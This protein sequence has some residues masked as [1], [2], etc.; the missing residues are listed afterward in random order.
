MEGSKRQIT[1]FAPWIVA[2]ICIYVA[3]SISHLRSVQVLA[4][5]ALF[6]SVVFFAFGYRSVTLEQKVPVKHGARISAWATVVALAVY[7]VLSR[8]P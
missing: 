7:L 2:N 6:L 8:W 3:A 4:F 5:L 1:I